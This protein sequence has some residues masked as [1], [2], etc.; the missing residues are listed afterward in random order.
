MDYKTWRK[1]NKGTLAQLYKEY[2]NETGDRKTGL[3]KFTRTMYANSKHANYL[4]E[5]E[6]ETG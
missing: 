3:E 4:S 6:K 5:M 1:K 2:Q